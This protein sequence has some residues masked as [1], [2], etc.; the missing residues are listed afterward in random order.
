M[1]EL[2]FNG[3]SSFAGDVPVENFAPYVEPRRLR[4]M[5]M[6]AKNALFCSFQALEQAH[7]PISEPKKMGLSIAVGAGSLENTCKFMDS[8]LDDGDELSSPTAFAGSVHN[9]TGL[10]L[11][12]FLKINGPCVSTGQFEASF[13][14]A[15]L[16][17][18]SFLHKGCCREVLIVAA[19][20]INGVARSY[21]PNH[22]DLF[23]SILRTPKGPFERAA[24]AII[25]GVEPIG[26]NPFK[27]IRTD[28]RR[29]DE[30]VCSKSSQS[31][32]TAMETVRL[33]QSGH[34]FEL[35]DNFA[36]TLFSL[37][38]IPYVK[39]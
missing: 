24:A 14:G 37:E 9:S 26:A 4:R 6:M 39:P 2:Y 12:L 33:L 21:A 27:L 38:A 16:S 29:T 11:S 34:P 10:A 3:F 23:K 15:L 32:F 7:L 1:A 20:D 25:L 5:E 31:A 22:P 35:T 28:F 8:I 17:A 19:E 30:M 13:A 36:G 18:I